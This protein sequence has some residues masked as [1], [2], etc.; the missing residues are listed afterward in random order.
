MAASMY[1]VWSA[2]EPGRVVY[3]TH[4]IEAITDAA[5]VHAEVKS[6]TH[7][8]ALRSRAHA[9]SIAEA[10]GYELRGEG[11]AWESLPEESPPEE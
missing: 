11:E 10:G 4:A 7:E 3:E 2:V 9:R 8:V 1:V 5:G 6:E